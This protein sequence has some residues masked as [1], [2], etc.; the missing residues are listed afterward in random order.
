MTDY[1]ERDELRAK[2]AR[3]EEWLD[4]F[5]NSTATLTLERDELRAENQKLH[6]AD[7]WARQIIERQDAEIDRLKAGR[8]RECGEERH[9][10]EP[11][12][13]AECSDERE[14]NAEREGYLESGQVR[15]VLRAEIERLRVENERLRADVAYWEGEYE[16]VRDKWE[17]E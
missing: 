2:L 17:S 6:V 14:G 11:W 13:H 16:T 5:Q 12:L 7:K 15:R 4:K 9:D 10:D 3:T 1:H 8:C